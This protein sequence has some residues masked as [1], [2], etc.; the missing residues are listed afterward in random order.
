LFPSGDQVVT[1]FEQMRTLIEFRA[2]LRSSSFT[3]SELQF[4]LAGLESPTLKFAN[5]ADTVTALVLEVQALGSTSRVEILRERLAAVFNVTTDHLDDMFGWI[6]ATMTD[7]AIATALDA[8][9]TDGVL[10]GP[11]DITPLV[12]LV[13]QL[14][15][16][17]TL[18]G[19]LKLADSSV[20]FLTANPAA[21]GIVSLSALTLHD[22]RSLTFYRSLATR[23]DD[24]EAQVQ[25]ALLAYLAAGTVSA[26]S[27]RARLADIFEVDTSLVDSLI[28]VL[29]LSTAPID[30]FSDLARG[31]ALCNTLGVNGYSLKKLGDDA[32]YDALTIAADVALG[33][34]A[35]KY[36]DETV[37]ETNL[38]P[39]ENRLNVLKRD[40]LCGYII[41]LQPE[42]KFADLDEIYNFFLL[43]VEMSGCFRTSRVVCAIS[44]AQLYIQRCLLNLEQSDPDLNPS[45]PDI[46]VDP[47]RVP[48]DEWEWRKNYRIW[49]ANRK[50]FLYPESYIDPNLRDDTTPIFDDLANDLLQKKIDLN[51]AT[52]AY[53]A[54]VTQ[55]AELAHLQ[56]CGSYYH[57][58]THTYY[59]FGRTQ[60]DPPVFYY[61]RWDQTTWSPWSK[62]ELAIDAPYV[63]AEVHLGRLYIFWVSGNSK[64]KTSIQGGES[65]FEY[66]QVHIDLN[67]S[68]LTPSGKW[69][70]PQKLPWL[71]PSEKETI[72]A[73]NKLFHED[74]LLE[75]ELSKTYR[76]VYP[77]TVGNT[78]L[79]RYYNEHLNS[80]WYFD[81]RLN[82]FRNKLT[83]GSGISDLSSSKAIIVFATSGAAKL[84]VETYDFKTEVYFDRVLEQPD[85]IATPHTH[86]SDAFAYTNWKNDNPGRQD[87][88][89]YVGN[90]YPESVFTFG[91]QQYLIHERPRIWLGIRVVDG[92]LAATPSANT[93][94]W[95][96]ESLRSS[97]NPGSPNIVHTAFAPLTSIKWIG[98]YLAPSVP[99]SSR[100]LVR[101]STSRADDLGEILF[102]DGLEQFFSLDTQSLTEKPLGITIT[103]LSELAPP[104]D[105]PNHLDFKGAFGGHYRELYLHIPWLIAFHLNANQRFED[106]LWWYARIFD[107]TASESPDD[108]K[109]TD[110]NWRYSEFRNLTVPNL[111]EILTDGAAIAAYKSDPFNPFAIARLRPTAFQKA[112]VMHYVSNLLDWGD[113][114]FARDTMESINEATTLYVLA[115]QI[116]GPRPAVLG[117]CETAPD[118]NLTYKKIGPA[119]DQGSEFLVT[120]ENWTYVST[121][122]VEVEKQSK[123][124]QWNALSNAM[125]GSM[126]SVAAAHA[127]SDRVALDRAEHQPLISLRDKA[128]MPF[129]RYRAEVRPYA[130]IVAERRI[131]EDWRRHWEV[132]PPIKRYPSH[133]VVSQSTLVFCVPQNE[134]L[135]KYWD[136]VEDRLFK[137]RNC[138]NISGVRR[139]LALF[140][141]PIN[142]MA[143][144][145][146]KAA[147]LSLEEALA[148][149]A[150]PVPAYRFSYL[151]ER[152]RQATALVQSFGASLLNALEKKD[153]EDLTL[154]R[155]VH[156][157][158][159][160][161]MTKD[162][163]RKQ[164]QEA[165]F[166][167][168]AAQA[169]SAT[170]Q[171]RIDYYTGLIESGLTGWEVTQQV[172][173]HSA[174]A[175]RIA[176]SVVHM[177]AAITYLIPQ[178]GS[179]FAMKYG[180]Q[181]LGHS[182]V[183]FAAWSQA[184]ASILEAASASAALEAT[185]Q[186]REQEWKQLLATANQELSQLGQQIHAAEM[187][188]AI[189]EKDL[190]IHE[191]TMQQT[192]EV[193]QF[194]KDKFTNL[195]LYNYLA[196][197]LT[198]LHREAYNTAHDLAAL[199][200]RAYRFETDDDTMFVAPDNWQFD[201]AGLLAGDRLAL[202]LQQLDSAYL[203]K[204]T[205]R[206]EVTQSFSVAQVAPRALIDLREIGVCEFSLAEVLFDLAYPGQY[207]RLIK[208]VRLTIPCV[209]GPYTNVSAKFTLQQSR[210]RTKPTTDPLDLVLMPIQTTPSIATSTAQNDGGLFEL[211]FRDERYLP[212]EGAG[213]V[214][215]WRLELPSQLRLIDYD[216]IG[217]VIIHVSYTALDD[218]LL[219][220]TVESQIVDELTTYASTVGMH[221]LFS[222]R[223]DLPNAFRQLMYGASPAQAT[224]FE[225]GAQHFPYFLAGQDLTIDGVSVYVQPTGADPVDTTGVKVSVNGSIADI[226]STPPKTSLRL[227]EAGVSGPALRNWTFSVTAG[228]L[229][230]KE[231]ANVLLLV[232]YAV[233]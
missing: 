148:A 169:N 77:K 192:D 191:T 59:F 67:Y 12:T 151:V 47:T 102:S 43:D 50:V 107:P 134:E 46:H 138:M 112:V 160:Q 21:V 181:E 25:G 68:Y 52:D 155:A 146:A 17:S 204:N 227:A 229:D 147:G 228:E 149:I 31:L 198:R 99:M 207:K 170:I 136:R 224:S 183:E 189:A 18:F 69:V 75:M 159:I 154:L 28:G 84:G 73:T 152:A 117:K 100:E 32:S 179:P 119:I 81:R 87:I 76:K 90:G 110:R 184:M 101:L 223:H 180:G 56:I 210:V 233:A 26:G 173:R 122:Q 126:A 89:H 20:G 226:W 172:T 40:A 137:I 132:E 54:Y 103:N 65:K 104:D 205:R 129:D 74:D 196:T 108:A 11:S 222:L 94:P 97:G 15:R 212:F 182:G 153:V 111:K 24:V 22:V 171:Q 176:E 140:Q 57:T 190:E 35:A 193:Y 27:E 157:S 128:V 53:R 216:T 95:R 39:Y 202:Q 206:Y 78:I 186:R 98:D 71:Y 221:R 44:S 144:V 91:D 37:R 167:L 19:I 219:R 199:A 225:L 195:G 36:E 1:S 6:S 83:S 86:I 185:F 165:Q 13:Q 203:G 230:S 3:T 162:V 214:S 60:Q 135:L 175:L 80:N 63:S 49:E 232:K 197:T 187:R 158:A 45:I 200:E 23:R 133:E 33:S 118:E 145:R 8:T 231:V 121:W 30:A 14:E 51:T 114:L 16:V 4:V 96:S 29:P 70:A 201:R 92:T 211:N 208:T 215:T 123:A 2:W 61:R 72:S 38:G 139:S 150:A 93:R 164:I 58:A 131:A 188:V 217:D 120:L 88:M 142:P 109:P 194:F 209:T 10:D 48:A 82:L 9:F 66:F 213:A 5:T 156:E 124:V 79:L 7:P 113:S 168:L 218:G 105:D 127:V 130:S 64:D 174:T 62:I 42:L 115:A 116:L 41:A 106:A 220:E 178:V 55:F 125:A 85:N 143:L 141:P 166:T 161:R 177:S 34:F 163:K